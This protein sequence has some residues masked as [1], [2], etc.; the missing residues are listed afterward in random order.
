MFENIEIKEGLDDYYGMCNTLINMGQ[1]KAD[2]GNFISAKPYYERALKLA[3]DIKATSLVMACYGHYSYYYELA[4][5]YKDALHY[6]I[7]YMD[8]MD[9]VYVAENEQQI[10]EMM[11]RFETEQKEKENEL[12]RQQ[13]EIQELQIYRQ[14]S[15]RNFFIILAVLLV[16][17]YLVAYSSRVR[18]S[19]SSIFSSREDKERTTIMATGTKTDRIAS[20]II[21]LS[22]SIASLLCPIIS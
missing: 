15:L 4:G 5:N 19:R 2:Q 8:L 3:K 11:V 7:L 10:A 21:P 13:S 20:Q 16:I 9:S 12:L 6:Q 22:I 17:S 18:A 14:R 1:L